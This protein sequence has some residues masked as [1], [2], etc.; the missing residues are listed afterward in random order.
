MFNLL[1]SLS[2]FII[3]FLIY[4]GYAYMNFSTT[5]K[6]QWWYIP[7]GLVLTVIGNTLWMIVTKLELSQHLLLIKGVIWDLMLTTTFIAVPL[8]FF[9]VKLNQLSIIGLII[10]IIGIIIMKLGLVT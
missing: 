2:T 8:L 5:I 4:V 6:D 7:L 3:A 10:S 9:S 1:I